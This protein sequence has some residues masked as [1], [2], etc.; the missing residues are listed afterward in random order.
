MELMAVTTVAMVRKHGD[1]F[2]K[3]LLE[4]TPVPPEGA[5]TALGE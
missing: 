1:N 3:R 5:N 4:E 2:E